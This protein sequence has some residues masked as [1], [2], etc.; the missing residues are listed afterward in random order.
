MHTTKQIIIDEFAKAELNL[1]FCWRVLTDLKEFSINDETF[2]NRFFAFQ[3]RL[4]L[5]I[6]NL[7]TIRDNII[8]EEKEYIFNKS[9]YNF[10]W[11]K[12]KMRILSN[13]KKGID[14][15]VGISKAL[16]DAF[17]YFFYQFDLELLAE[18]LSHQRIIN[19][20]AGAGE[21]GELEFITRI[22]QIEGHFT[23]FHGIT[24]ILRYGDYSFI[25]LKNLK[26]VKIGELKTK[27]VDSNTI[28]LN[29]TLIKRE[30]LNKNKV[31]IKDPKL[32]KTRNERQIQGIVNFLIEKV[33]S[34]NFEVNQVNK[35]YALDIE[36][37]IKQA[38]INNNS[39][40]Q[41]SE[42]L[43]FFCIKFK[44]T[45]LFNRIFTRDIENRTDKIS[46]NIAEVT[47]KLLKNGSDNN[48]IIMGQLLYNSDFSDKN[49][50]GTIPL[51]WHHINNNLLKRLYFTDCVVISL[52]NPIHLINEIEEMG[53]IV[54]SK[55]N[56]N[57]CKERTQNGKIVQ[58]F[59]LFISYIINFLM[60]ES[61]V[62]SA[63]KDVLKSEFN[64]KSKQII[65][66]LQQ[67]MNIL[68]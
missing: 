15:V 53:F 45:T 55:Y 54:E 32:L 35:S 52:F 61:F 20:T 16:G 1:E 7:Q 67:Q 8:I 30:E 21:R 44:K 38:K 10:E 42:G 17:A 33:K 36:T 39:S 62:T 59:D 63:I 31:I 24:N 60:T 49:T 23:L 34:N 58:R 13:F 2:I 28:D 4:A 11:F 56:H 43:A 68:K 26:V 3:D 6:F 27:K 66:R 18:H 47:A 65:L 57:N 37:L 29:I 51:F 12:A 9:N 25:D 50:P 19:N 48:S 64:N 41:V 5:T 40:I 14:N 46:E 22:K